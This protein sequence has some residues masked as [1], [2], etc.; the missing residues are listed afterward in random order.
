MPS[1]SHIVQWKCHKK[2]KYRIV[3]I[4]P[5]SSKPSV[6][7]QTSQLFVLITEQPPTA[8]VNFP[9]RPSGG[10]FPP[11]AWHESFLWPP[12]WPPSA[13]AAYA[14]SP[15][16]RVNLP[17]LIKIASFVGLSLLLCALV[18]DDIMVLGTSLCSAG[19]EGLTL[20]KME[21]CSTILWWLGKK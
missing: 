8:D 15:A 20:G 16:R 17:A 14:L 12:L 6:K 4:S 1:P 5:A 9:A 18:P 11:P 19:S 10:S 3:H 2:W 21:M 7:W 13:W